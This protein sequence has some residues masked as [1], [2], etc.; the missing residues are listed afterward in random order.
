MDVARFK[1]PPHWVPLECMFES[2]TLFDASV[3]LDRGYAVLCNGRCSSMVTRSFAVSRVSGLFASFK[4]YFIH[5]EP[6]PATPSAEFPWKLVFDMPAAVASFIVTFEEQKSKG[7]AAA[8]IDYSQEC[9]ELD[10]K[11]VHEH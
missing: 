9:D 5:L 6:D 4:G 1:H 3:S 10:S 2:M 11:M 8:W 7:G